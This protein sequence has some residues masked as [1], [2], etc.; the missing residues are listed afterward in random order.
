MKLSHR[1]QLCLLVLM[2]W[3]YCYPRSH[4]LCTPSWQNFIRKGLMKFE[5]TNGSSLISVIRSMVGPI[6]KL[7]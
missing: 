1:H 3:H 7:Q 6:Q 5:D 2:K 4:A